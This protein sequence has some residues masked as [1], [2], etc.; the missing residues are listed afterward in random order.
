[1]C[2]VMVV[3]DDA[4]IRALVAEVLEDDGHHVL[5]A[6]NGQE[7]LDL[8]RGGASPALI[9]LDMM[10]PVLSGAELL[11]LMQDDRA[12]SGFPVVVVSAFANE[13]NAK[14]V[15]RFVRKPVSASTLRELVE[16][17]AKAS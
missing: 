13:G 10:M 14:G 12:L 9:L 6:A 16:T 15:A 7:A 4:D 11:E 5:Q 8:L 3:E 17:Y 1:M 2:T